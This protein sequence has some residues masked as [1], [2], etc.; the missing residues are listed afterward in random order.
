[1]PEPDDISLLR[2]YVETHSEEAFGTLVSRHINKVYS[3]ALRHTRNPHQAEEITQAVFVILARRAGGLGKRVILSGW[4]YQTA[5]LASVTFLRSEI[6]RTRRE[7]EAHMQNILNETAFDETWKQIGPLLDAAMARL[8]T[9]DRHAVVL[10]YFDGKSMRDVGAALGTTEDAAKKRLNRALEKL[11]KFFTKHGVVSSTVIIAGAISANSVQAAPAALAKS[12]TAVA[13]AKGAAASISTLTLVKGALKIMA[14]TKAQTAVVIGAAAILTI[15]GTTAVVHHVVSSRREQFYE[16]IFE[17]PDGSSLGKL[18]Q[19]PPV[20]IVRPTRYPDKPM[21]FGTPDGR[22]IYDN[23]EL[24]YLI[25]RAY[26]GDPFHEILPEDA[27]KGGYDY[28]NTL[29]NANDALREE[30]KK[31]FGLVARREMHPT[32]VL[33]LQATDP[34]KLESFRTKGG[35]FA[36]YGTGSG[37]TQFRYFTNAPLSLLAAQIGEGY[38]QKPCIDTTEAN[39]KYDFALQWEEPAGLTGEARLEALRPI[40]E[41]QLAQLGLELV[42][43][44]MPVEMLM[45]EKVN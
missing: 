17:H 39:A 41:R 19:C 27:P 37:D 29:P 14:W 1:M 22:E 43:T 28:L 38:F 40:I 12:V 34:F 31:Q 24:S 11:R 15:G 2:E 10:R 6:R 4:L 18:E 16:S 9:T 30:I 42:P 36:C 44:N 32:D 20:L 45:V 23:T 33:L 21:G 26:N 3:A 5:R 7:Q 13:L 35:P 25:A 8:N